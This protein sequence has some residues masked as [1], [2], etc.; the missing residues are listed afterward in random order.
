MFAK[1]PSTI[2]NQKEELEQLSCPSLIF[3]NLDLGILANLVYKFFVEIQV[4]K[5]NPKNLWFLGFF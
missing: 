1:T 2:E 5:K 3:N 4:E